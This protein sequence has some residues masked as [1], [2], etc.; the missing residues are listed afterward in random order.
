MAAGLE[1]PLIED[2]LVQA[3]LGPNIPTRLL[4]CTCCRLGHAAHHRVVLADRS[5]GLVQVVAAG[6]AD[7]AVTCEELAKIRGQFEVCE[8]Y[9]AELLA[10]RNKGTQAQTKTDPATNKGA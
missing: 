10:M 3:G 7:A 2:G 6:V 1:A 9:K 5:R 4:G 8:D